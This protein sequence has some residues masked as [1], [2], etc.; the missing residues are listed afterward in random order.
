MPKVKKTESD[1]L[2]FKSCKGKLRASL[3]VDLWEAISALANTHGGSI[4]L[5]VADDGTIED[6]SDADIDRLQKD[7]SVL[8]NGKTLNRRPAVEIKSHGTFVELIVDEAPFYE[9][10]IYGRKTGEKKIYI[11][12]GAT[13]VRAD[14]SQKRSMFAGASGGGENQVVEG[15]ALALV[16]GRKVDEYIARTG[17]KDV[18]GLGLAEKLRK[19]K[20]IRDNKLTIFGLLA[21]TA[22]GE[23]DERLN[24]TY[25]DFKY[26][27]GKTKVGD[28]L[29]E[30]YKDR[31]EFHG[32]IKAQFEQ[33]FEYLMRYI[34]QDWPVGGVVNKET[35]LRENVYVLPEVAFR[36][37]LANAVAHRD[38]MVDG[39]CVNINL[40][41]DRVEMS[42][43][44]ESLVAIEDLDKT[45]SRARNPILME[46]LKAFEITD[47]S[48]RG[49]LTIK[50]AARKK[51]LLDPK[52]EN[53]SG[54]FK[55]TLYFSSPHSDNDK[56]WLKAR[57]EQYD[58]K[59]SQKNAII[60]AKNNPDAG[61]GN[62]EY[63]DINHMDTVGD[64]IRAK[65]ELKKLVAI[66]VLKAAGEKRHRR[67]YF[68]AD[69]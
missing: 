16:D 39:S 28:D 25:I 11:R 26:F 24:N 5:G 56:A 46:Y 10:P 69:F 48:A 8:I 7:A 29:G 6:L 22:A 67:Y 62:G 2:E 47:K 27:N 21:F 14:D 17:L 35:G 54:S 66:G 12:Q 45:D 51:G 50:Q 3:P 34:K 49:I 53:I 40:Y 57:L 52:F 55:S 61:I 31:K 19:L 36:E 60:H 18:T 68:N 42:N 33:A 37:A 30:I 63:R 58:L 65:N 38:Y 59:D 15:D 20:A 13:T 9:K 23:I 4:Y 43:P 44:G 41:A 32:D 1:T 64:D